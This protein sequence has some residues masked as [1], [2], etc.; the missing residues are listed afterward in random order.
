MAMR[1]AAL[2][3]A[4]M[5]LAGPV[6]AAS[7]VPEPTVDLGGTSFLDG[8][9]GPGPMIEVI[10]NGTTAGYVTDAHGRAVDG[11]NGQSSAS[12]TLH[13]AYVS[14]VP[15]LGGHLGIE[16]LFPFAAVRLHVP[17]Q[18]QTT[19]GGVG[20]ITIA[21]FIQWSGLSLAGHRFAMRLGLQGVVP[22]GTYS[23]YRMVSIGD[24]LWQIS[25]YYAFTFHA[26]DRWEISG[27]LIY[28]WA[29]RNTNPPTALHAS[30]AQPGDQF[31]MNLSVS[32]ALSPSWR[33]GVAGYAL[34]QLSD[35]RVDGVA[36]AG[37]QQQ[38]FA[39]GPGVL[40]NSGPVTMIGNVFREFAAQNRPEG[41]EAILRLLCPF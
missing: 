39:I 34:K 24:N 28:D 10:G 37:S 38:V 21:P 32:Y 40:W 4:V 19:Q 22:T 33:V 6:R 26:N 29:S 16:F 36:V 18:P 30:S 31:A 12:L 17:G 11:K 2:A 3:V 14:D 20:D 25:P 27:R 1:A 7:P 5:L 13:P 35:T 23:P 8:E 15:V 41:F 9:A